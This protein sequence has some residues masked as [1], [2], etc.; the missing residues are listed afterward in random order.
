MSSECLL[1]YIKTSAE[2][3]SASAP[4]IRWAS[5]L[6]HYFAPQMVCTLQIN[7]V[8]SAI[9]T[10]FVL[11][12]G[13]Y[14]WVRITKTMDLGK[15]LAYGIFVL[16]VEVRLCCNLCKYTC[17]LMLLPDGGVCAAAAL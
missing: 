17:Y 8:G 10:F 4:Y 1:T 15:Y 6:R 5:V 13:F 3:I 11:A 9:F 2:E 14:L 16:V 7:W 12:F